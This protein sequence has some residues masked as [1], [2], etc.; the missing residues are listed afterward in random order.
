[1]GVLLEPETLQT[2]K[3]SRF[4]MVPDELPKDVN[5]WKLET[6]IYDFG[7]EQR[8]DKLYLVF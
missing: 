7:Y 5:Q 3:K 4:G 8:G 2:Y 6:V 1:M